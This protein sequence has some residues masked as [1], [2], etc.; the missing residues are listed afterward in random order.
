MPK[1]DGLRSDEI[2]EH[3]LLGLPPCALSFGHGG[4]QFQEPLCSLRKAFGLQLNLIPK[5]ELIDF[6]KKGQKTAVPVLQFAG[7]KGDTPDLTR[8]DLSCKLVRRGKQRCKSPG[9]GNHHEKL[10]ILLLLQTYLGLGSDISECCCHLIPRITPIAHRSQVA[11]NCSI[12]PARR[13]FTV[14]ISPGFI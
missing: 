3:L 2:K 14:I 11:L 7:L 6:D 8:V 10:P 5:T 12:R 1:K 4:S 13:I 9:T